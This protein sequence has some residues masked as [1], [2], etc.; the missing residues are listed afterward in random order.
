MFEFQFQFPCLDYVY[1][2]TAEMFFIFFSCKCV[3]YLFHLSFLHTVLSAHLFAAP[4]PSCFCWACIRL[5]G[6]CIFPDLSHFLVY[7]CPSFPL[8]LIVRFPPTLYCMLIYVA[9]E[10]V[11]LATTC[12][13]KEMYENSVILIMV[14]ELLSY[15]LSLCLILLCCF[16]R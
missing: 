13:F 10:R 8:L 15:Y 9:L 1:W 3:E 6:Y 12:L 4:A 14:T 16:N 2:R 11:S 5:L 7:L